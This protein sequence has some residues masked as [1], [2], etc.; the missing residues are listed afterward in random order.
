VVFLSPSNVETVI[1]SIPRLSNFNIHHLIAH[2][3]LPAQVA[4]LATGKS[5]P[6]Q[7]SLLLT[8]DD[9]NNLK[10]GCCLVIRRTNAFTPQILIFRPLSHLRKASITFLMYASGRPSART[11][12]R[13]Y[14]TDFREI[15]YQRFLIKAAQKIQIWVKSDKKIGYFA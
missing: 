3:L 15:W 12:L 4:N 9:V 7:L 6:L 14:W 10:Y 5:L 13:S 2:I 8:P 1:S 11:Y